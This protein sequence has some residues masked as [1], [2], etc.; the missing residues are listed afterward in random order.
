MKEKDFRRQTGVKIETYEKMV[1]I[2]KKEYA[3][4]HHRRGR[5]QKLSIEDLLLATLEYL[6]E[7]RTYAH[8]AA[9]YDI[10][11]SNIYR[12][13]RWGEDTLI[14]AG[15][16]SLPGRKALLKSDVE[17]EVILVDA[18]ETPIERPQKTKKILLRKEK[19]SYLKNSNV[20]KY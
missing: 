10:A 12:G 7:Y 16:F 20:D 18:T 19:T 11:E 17:Y 9:S 14:K 13:I 1:E 8:I 15:T 6:R 4:K 2:L 5:H 3:S